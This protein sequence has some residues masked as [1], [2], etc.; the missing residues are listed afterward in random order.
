MAN[1]E[2]NIICVNQN[3]S[4][5]FTVT[6]NLHSLL[7]AWE[8]TYGGSLSERANV[9]IRTSDN[10]YVV[11]GNTY[12]FTYPSAWLSPR[13]SDAYLLKM[14]NTVLFYGRDFMA[15][16]NRKK[17]NGRGDL[18]PTFFLVLIGK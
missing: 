18:A 13:Y 10:S 4:K 11:A 14:T 5:H 9:S 15:A 12:S 3:N 8:R 2:Q 6:I 1:V 7:F 17:A 16:K